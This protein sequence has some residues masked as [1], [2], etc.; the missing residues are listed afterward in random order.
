MTG[1]T[2]GEQE[3]AVRERLAQLVAEVDATRVRAV[4]QAAA[5]ARWLLASLLAVNGGAAVALLGSDRPP[6]ASLE[7]ALLWFVVG[8]V[9]A[10]ATGLCHYYEAEFGEGA[11]EELKESIRQ[12]L[13]GLDP[14]AADAAFARKK[15]GTALARRGALLLFPVSLGAFVLGVW[16]AHF[17]FR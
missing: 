10:V 13:A 2:E 8:V 11:S 4:E 6:S 5:M 9:A 1:Q 14:A 7:M 17:L 16:Q 3:K 15:R 12:S